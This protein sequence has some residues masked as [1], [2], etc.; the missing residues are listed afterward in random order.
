MSSAESPRLELDG[1]LLVVAV[2]GQ[3]VAFRVRDRRLFC[4]GCG[5]TSQ[6][7][8]DIC[9][10]CD[11]GRLTDPLRPAPTLPQLTAKVLGREAPKA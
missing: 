5:A 9:Y 8:S 7:P 3:E 10:G 2:G 6:P 1:K 11:G 4:P